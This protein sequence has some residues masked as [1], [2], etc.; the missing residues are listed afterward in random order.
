MSERAYFTA[1]FLELYANIAAIVAFIEGS[2]RILT[3]RLLSNV[4][5][6]IICICIAAFVLR[7][8]AQIKSQGF[9]YIKDIW[10]WHELTTTYLL[11]ISVVH[12]NEY[13]IWYKEQGMDEFKLDRQLMIATG[14]LLITQIIFY[15][16]STFL[17]VRIS[18]LAFF[19]FVLY[20]NF[21]HRLTNN[22]S[23]FCP[24]YKTLS[25]CK[26]CRWTSHNLDNLNSFLRSFVSV[27]FGVHIFIQ[28]IC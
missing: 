17:P 9:H 5:P 2:E 25:V 11:A 7:E 4:E 8:L 28:G 20:A 1:L 18:T 19:P 22:Y 21:I 6:T 23:F 24:H 26:I 3:N 12:M 27:A 10:S 16:R 15:C 13:Q 14:L